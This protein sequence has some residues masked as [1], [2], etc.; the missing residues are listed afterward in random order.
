MRNSTGFKT[1]AHLEKME[2]EG[3][4]NQREEKVFFDHIREFYIHGTASLVK[5]MPLN[6][7]VIADFSM[8]DP[9]KSKDIQGPVK[10]LAGRFQQLVS[11]NEIDELMEET[12]LYEADLSV[13]D[14]CGDNVD[15]YWGMVR[16]MMDVS[17]G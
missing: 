7:P 3:A 1:S 15:Q 11:E 8:L 10:R 4:V 2:E 9:A 14:M 5:K 12:F 16:E 6:D 17:T 13:P